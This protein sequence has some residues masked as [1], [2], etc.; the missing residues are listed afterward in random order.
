[1]TASERKN[2]IILAAML[3]REVP[4]AAPH[5]IADTVTALYRLGRR[6]S[7]VAVRLC[8]GQI[9]QEKYDRAQERNERAA[10]AALLTLFTADGK[11][12]DAL[13]DGWAVK[14]GGDPRGYCLRLFT[15]SKPHNTWGGEESGWGVG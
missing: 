2:Q 8:N 7:N 4:T 10:E 13:P 6:A 15:P 12:P 9:E 14:T 5:W 3:A 1:M 11:R